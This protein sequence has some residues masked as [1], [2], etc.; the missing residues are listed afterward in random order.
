[1]VDV[2]TTLQSAFDFQIGLIQYIINVTNFMK[3]FL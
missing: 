3:N 1:M 2:S